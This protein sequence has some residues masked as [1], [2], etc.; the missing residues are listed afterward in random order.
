MVPVSG[1]VKAGDQG[2]FAVR[3]EQIRIVAQSPETVTESQ[4]LGKIKD[5]LYIGDVTTYI[6]ALANGT[7]I[8]ALLP[9]SVPGHAKLFDIGDSVVISWQEQSAQFLPD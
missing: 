5:F 3:P 9:N 8:E 6:I 1:H 4:L 2:V 7:L